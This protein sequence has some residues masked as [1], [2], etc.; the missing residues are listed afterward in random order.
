[1]LFDWLVREGFIVFSWW[2]LI[3]L[4]GAAVFPL[5]VRLLSGLPDKGYTLTRA[6][7]VLMTGFVFWLL[8]SL[9]FLRNGAG[10]IVLS[11][12]IVLLVSLIIYSRVSGDFS[13]RA[14]WSENRRVVIVAELLF[15]VLL[16][17]WS[18]YRAHQ[19]GLY[20]T[21]KPMDLAF[22]S[23]IQ[24]SSIFPPNDPWMAGYAI[25]Y[26][27]FGYVISAMLSMMSGIPST[28]GFNMNIAMLFAL[29]GLTTFGVV[30]NLVRSRAVTAQVV[31]K[32]RQQRQ[33]LLTGLLG[34]MFMVL[35][36]NF[37]TILVEIPYRTMAVSEDYLRFWDTKERD[38]YYGR[39]APINLLD[40]NQAA[41]S[42]WWWFGASRTITD[43]DLRG[44]RATEVIDEF[45]QF[46]F[47]LA[48]NHP[49]VMSLPYAILAMGLALNLLLGRRSPTRYEVVFYGLCLGALVFLNTWDCPIYIALMLGAE[50]LRRLRQAGQLDRSDYI[51][52][53]RLGAVLLGITVLAYLPFLLSFRS[54]LAGILPNLLYPT[55]LQQYF[56]M[57]GPFIIILGVFLLVEA[58]RGMQQKQMNWTLGLQTSAL[59]LGLLLFAMIGLTVLGWQ[60]SS[61]IRTVALDFVD[62]N[63]GWS[64]VLPMLLGRWLT[65]GVL[66]A[67]FTL[68]GITTAAARL[69]PRRTLLANHDESAVPYTTG[70]GFA[71]LLVFGGLLLTFIPD[72][73]YLRDNFGHRMNTIFKFYYQAWA[74]FSVASAYGVYTLLWESG[75]QKRWLSTIRV[76]FAAAVL[77]GMVYPV[78]GIYHRAFLET[79]RLLAE[80]PAL[81]TL[82]G[83]PSF[84]HPDDYAV[85]MCLS[86]LVRGD[87]VVVAEAVGPQYRAEF[88]RV[89]ALTGLPIVIGWEGHQAQWRGATYAQVAGSRAR[90]MIELF[91]DLRWD[92]AQR[93]IQRYGIDYILFGTSE[94]YGQYN[95]NIRYNPSGEEK[96]LENLEI[97]CEQ[98]GSRIFSTGAAAQVRR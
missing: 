61:E 11:W 77:G 17:G 52:V 84:I 71:L 74:M 24:R 7:G 82:D 93:I 98:G 60:A 70:T 34:M 69:F 63:G 30:Y 66:M 22:M 48:D 2:L 37:Q 25:S 8:A 15:V 68:S 62:A 18:I 40:P 27:Y 85:I 65:Y 80:Q 20:G 36:G 28:I 78:L 83:G 45:P 92:V 31:D 33:A 72:Y 14:W 6:A 58:R 79:R 3:T 42:N 94:R 59:I 9:G 1:M 12:F 50:A 26:Y 32:L 13:W 29:T 56:V 5:S 97:V 73:V 51:E 91:T 86:N 55:R 96:F 41:E 10:S 16:V 67:L 46:S 75:L 47:L 87:N 44:V 19:N 53:L 39:T 57:F 88:G 4:A 81:L 43:R 90:D 23:A 64:E 21:E 49:H 35:M 76:V 95:N 89:G 54:Q 38:S